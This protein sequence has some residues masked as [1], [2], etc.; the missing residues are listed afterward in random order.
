MAPSP[1]SITLTGNHD[2]PAI[3][4]PAVAFNPRALGLPEAIDQAIG[5][6]LTMR[7]RFRRITT[8]EVMLFHGPAGWGEFC[9]FPEYGPPA[10]SFWLAS[11]LEA[12]IDGWPEPIRQTIP[13]NATVPA[14]SPDQA[15]QIVQSTNAQTVKVKV[16]DPGQTIEDDLARLRAVREALGDEG[17]IRMDANAAWTVDEAILRISAYNEAARP[18]SAGADTPGLEYV[19]QPC[20]TLEEL[21]RVRAAT[22]VRIA[23][24]ESI[25]LAQNPFDLSGLHEAADVMIVKVAPLGGV[26]RALE[27]I[28]VHQLPAVVSSALESAVGMRAGVALAACAPDLGGACGLGT[29]QLFNQDLDWPITTPFDVTTR[30]PCPGSLRNADRVEGIARLAGQLCALTGGT[31]M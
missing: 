21:A 4:L 9:P 1:E 30:P 11:A 18:S 14:V 10:T 7:H 23:A 17:L 20:K 13:I 27:I 26:L 22:G 19:E 15:K 24:D 2:G 8:R 25:R 16:A 3:D 12:A 5:V 31:A 29:G 28:G 6:Q